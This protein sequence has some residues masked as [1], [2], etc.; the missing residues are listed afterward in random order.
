[1]RNIKRRQLIVVWR[2]RRNDVSGNDD[3][4]DSGMKPK[5]AIDRWKVAAENSRSWRR[6]GGSKKEYSSKLPSL[7]DLF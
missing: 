2:N 7:N 5:I 1:V 6:N 4:D 3:S